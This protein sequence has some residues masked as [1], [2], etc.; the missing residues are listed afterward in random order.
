M[1]IAGIYSVFSVFSYVYF[2]FSFRS[3]RRFLQGGTNLGINL[4][5]IYLDITDQLDP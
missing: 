1:I 3:G 5:L 4:F 2:I